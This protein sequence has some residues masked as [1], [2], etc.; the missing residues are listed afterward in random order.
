M[1]KMLSLVLGTQSFI[2]LNNIYD[3]NLSHHS[4]ALWTQRTVSCY[5][6][7]GEI[8]LRCDLKIRWRVQ[9]QNNGKEACLPCN[10]PKFAS[11]NP[12]WSPE[13]CQELFSIT[14]QEANPEHCQEK[15][16]NEN[17]QNQMKAGYILSKAIF[18][19]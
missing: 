3:L 6:T 16:Q 9:R 15:H 5:T 11:W 10:R 7:G 2:E 12:M 4:L 17:K 19:L 18:H 1:Y 14:L 8:S 13:S